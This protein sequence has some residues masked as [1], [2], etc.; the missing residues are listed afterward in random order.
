M[1]VTAVA[2]I[3]LLLGLL[4]LIIEAFGPGGYLIIPGGVLVILGL[5]GFASPDD[6]YTLW[7]PVVAIIACIPVTAFTVYLYRKLGSPEPPSTTVSDSLIGRDGMTVVE[8]S[9]DNLKG[10]VRIG[11]DTW[12]A[13]A[14]E[15][16]PA[17][18]PVSV[19]HS[20]GVHVRVVRK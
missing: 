6:F 4:L 10:K 14:D 17:G 2:V 11:S 13:T 16:I 1:E 7:T 9:P 8:I 3:V 15:I 5:F 20:E 12:S 18:T 19:V